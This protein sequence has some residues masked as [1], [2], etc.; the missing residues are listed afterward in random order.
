MADFD[1]SYYYP[2]VL[3]GLNFARIQNV[4]P[5]QEILIL[6][7][8]EDNPREKPIAAIGIRSQNGKDFLT[9]VKRADGTVLT[10]TLPYA[11]LLNLIASTHPIT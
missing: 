10:N 8:R 7:R 1:S 6:V 3:D 9:V 5:G 2:D 11:L 4:Q